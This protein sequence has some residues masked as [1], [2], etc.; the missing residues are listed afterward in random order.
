MNIFGLAGPWDPSVLDTNSKFVE[1]P[2]LIDWWM[3][4]C[5]ILMI[6]SYFLW[7]WRWIPAQDKAQNTNK[8]N[9]GGPSLHVSLN[10][11]KPC[12]DLFFFMTQHVVFLLIMDMESAK[13][14]VNG[15][16]K[17]MCFLLLCI[18]KWQKPPKNVSKPYRPN[19]YW[20]RLE[21]LYLKKTV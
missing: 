3:E 21:F 13:S 10:K 15:R 16:K 12:W 9:F 2:L 14:D 5:K 4:E 11:Y 18:K 6:F 8:N 1:S 19:S 7:K 20:I 17:K